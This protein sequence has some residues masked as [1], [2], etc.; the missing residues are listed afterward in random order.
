MTGT[1]KFSL[2]GKVAIVT[3]A[4]RGNGRAI[5]DALAESGA[6]TYFV[7]IVA[8]ENFKGKN[9]AFLQTEITKVEKLTKLVSEIISQKGKI[10]ILV[11]NAG[12]SLGGTT[13]ENYSISDWDQTLD[14][15]LKAPFMLSKLVAKDMIKLKTQGSII[16]VTSLAAVQ[17]FPDNPA[18]VAAKGGLS[19]LTKAMARDWAK[20]GIRVNNLCPGYIQ[21]KM[22]EKSYAD[23]ELHK[24]RLDRMMLKRWGQPED[25]TGA[26]VFLASDDSAYVTGSDIVV[27]GGWLAN[28]L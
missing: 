26:A 13:S 24:I 14:I 19:Q 21:T 1:E 22:T 2:K 10:D 11:N 3:G 20:Y 8:V 15:N 16:N 9:Q 4:A 5:A 7:D 27:D 17:G 12:I 28:G 25:L 6:F 18:Y 23:P